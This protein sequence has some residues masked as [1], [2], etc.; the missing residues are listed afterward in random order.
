MKFK[1]AI[2]MEL[3]YMIS[4]TF[5]FI[6]WLN[7]TNAEYFVMYIIFRINTEFRVSINFFIICYLWLIE[8]MG[9]YNIRQKLSR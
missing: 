9:L 6:L 3:D 2:K 4:L 7:I 1:H 5:T 8:M